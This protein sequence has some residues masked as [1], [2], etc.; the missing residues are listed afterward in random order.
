MFKRDESSPM[1]RS[2]AFEPMAEGEDFSDIILGSSK[3]KAHDPVRDTVVGGDALNASKKAPKAREPGSTA[4]F[5]WASIPVDLLI[6]YYDEIRQH[7][8]PTA[9]KDVDMESELLLQFHAVRALQTS[10]LNDTDI[11]LN[12]R[13]QVANTVASTLKSLADMQERI[14]TAERYK[15]IENLM[16]RSLNRLP[17]DVAERFLTEYKQILETNG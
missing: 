7:L 1:S 14:Y 3:P 17:E 13:A 11:A 16:I 5:N 15:T 12:Q 8:P 4:P 6:Q 10:V 2:P 9:L